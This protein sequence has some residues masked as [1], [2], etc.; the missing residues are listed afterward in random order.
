MI[1]EL[2][3]MQAFWLGHLYHASVREIP[4]SEYAV[5]QEFTLAVSA[6]KS[7]HLI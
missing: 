5:Q 1:Q 6:L 3:S 2:N 7:T 4:L